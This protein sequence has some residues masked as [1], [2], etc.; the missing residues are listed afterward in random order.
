MVAYLVQSPNLRSNRNDVE[1]EVQQIG[2]SQRLRHLLRGTDISGLQWLEDGK[3]ISILIREANRV[4]VS[5]IDVATG[6]LE[7]LARARQSI[8]EYSISGDGKTIAFAIEA[9]DKAHPERRTPEDTERGYRIPFQKEQVSLFLSR[10]VFV[11]R[12]LNGGRWTTPELIKPPSPF[13][14]M[15]MVAL[16]Y[17]VNLRMSLSPNGALLALTY[18]E[19]AGRISG[20]W[21]QSPAL[22][23]I[24]SSI[25]VAEIAAVVNLK[26]GETLLPF[27]GPWAWSIPLWSRDSSA[28]M[29]VAVSPVNSSWEED[30]VRNHRGPSDA[31]HLFH[32][33]VKSGKVTQVLTDLKG[34]YDR[35]LSWRSDNDLLLRTSDNTLSRFRYEAGQWRELSRFHLPLP[36]QFRNAELASDGNV[37]VGD[38]EAPTTPP[39]LFVYREGDEKAQTLAKLNPQFDE[40]TLAPAKEI[41]WDTS[42][43]YHATGLLFVPPDYKTGTPYPLVIHA[44]PAAANFF[45]DSGL[46]HDPSFAPQPIANAGMMYLIRILP[47]GTQRREEE[48]HYPKGYPGHL[49]EAAF[50]ADVWDSAVDDLVQKGLVDRDKVGIIGFSR[51]GWYTEFAL[52]HGRTHYAAAT[53]TDNTQYSLGEYWM[54]HSD[55]VLHGWDA[56]YGGPP[57]GETLQHWLDYSISFNLPKIH[58]PILMEEMG[59]GVAYDGDNAPPSNLALKWEVFA[60]LNRLGKPVELYYYPNEHHQPDHPQARLASLERNLEWY[61]FWLQGHERSDPIDRQQYVR[62]RKLRELSRHSD[63]NELGAI[64]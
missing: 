41:Q 34:I 45:C 49:A 10:K 3:T 42:T 32:V 21:K 16:P 58:T 31:V 27:E 51:S 18:L 8:S 46:N 5:K 15:R 2:A 50:H 30:D 22:R 17:A 14:R 56:M 64:R 37:V 38:Y 62:W 26:T 12:R 9:V 40:L 4:V 13:T 53:V 44:Y 6:R 63:G 35:P 57:Y 60:G 7:V 39:E 47:Q 23:N 29:I 28:F 20:S 61:R 25:G 52:S 33:E 59:N 36:G 43:G 1:L 11:T 19:N 54:I 55:G 24:L 48:A